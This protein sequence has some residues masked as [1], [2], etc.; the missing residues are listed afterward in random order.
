MWGVK[1]SQSRRCF[2][3]SA[4][5]FTRRIDL[6]CRQVCSSFM[7]CSLLPPKT[8]NWLL[9]AVAQGPS[10]IV[11]CQCRRS[12]NIVNPYCVFW[13]SRLDVKSSNSIADSGASGM[14]DWRVYSRLHWS[15]WCVRVWLCI[16]WIHISH[17]LLIFDSIWSYI[18][19]IYLQLHVHIYVDT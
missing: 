14:Q 17:I 7:Y 19:D 10:S 1:I 11:Y 15:C 6:W 8:S 3:N 12:V 5:Y 2:T 9:V 13:E 18:V 4:L 16:S